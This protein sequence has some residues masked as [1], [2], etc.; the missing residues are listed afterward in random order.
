MEM[1]TAPCTWPEGVFCGALPEQGSGGADGGEVCAEAVAAKHTTSA[2][3]AN[4]A[5]LAGIVFNL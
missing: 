3:M 4:S 5:V 1:R 2:G